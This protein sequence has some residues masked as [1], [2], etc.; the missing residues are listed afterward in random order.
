MFQLADDDGGSPDEFFHAGPTD[1]AGEPR[2]VYRTLIRWENP[3]GTVTDAVLY[4]Q[5]P[6]CWW[7]PG[8]DIWAYSLLEGWDEET[9]WAT[10]PEADG[11]LYHGVND[12]TARTDRSAST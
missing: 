7:S 12:G 11:E 8:P 3:A 1:V 6:D 2:T 4:A 10:Q 9:D 5:E